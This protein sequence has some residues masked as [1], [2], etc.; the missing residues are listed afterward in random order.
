MVIWAR[1]LREVSKKQKKGK[2]GG[3]GGGNTDYSYYGSFA[4]YIAHN[5]FGAVPFYR[6][7]RV[8]LN[9][10]LFYDASGDTSAVTEGRMRIHLG[11]TNQDVDPMLAAQEPDGAN[12]YDDEPYLSPAYRSGQCVL[13]FDDLP[14]AEYNN[15]FPAVSAEVSTNP[16][17][18]TLAAL[19]TSI[20]DRSNV[21]PANYSVTGLSGN[22]RGKLIQGETSAES[23]LSDLMDVYAFEPVDLDGITQFLHISRSRDL[24]P[25]PIEYLGSSEAGNELK[26]RVKTKIKP[27]WEFPTSIEVSYIDQDEDYNKRTTIYQRSDRDERDGENLSKDFQIVLNPQQGALLAQQL[28]HREWR[29]RIE[30]VFVLPFYFL[31]VAVG[32]LIELPDEVGLPIQEVTKVN[33]GANFAIEL[34]TI[35]YN[36][37]YLG[38]IRNIISVPVPQE[39]FVQDDTHLQILD[40]PSPHDSYKD[41]SLFFAVGADSTWRGGELYVSLDG[42]RYQ[43]LQPLT[44]RDNTGTTV[45]AL[46]T[47]SHYFFDSH[48]VLRVELAHDDQQLES[49]DAAAMDLGYNIALVG[50]EIIQFQNATL[51]VD[52]IWELTGLRRG[53]RGTEQE[54]DN[55]AVGDRFVVLT[56]DFGSFG[57]IEGNPIYIGETLHF[58]APNISQ[59][60][61]GVPAIN[62][63]VAGTVYMPP[64]PDHLKLTANADGS[65][66]V[67]WKIRARCRY[68]W[69]NGQD[70]QIPDS[71]K[72]AWLDIYDGN[73]LLRTIFSPDP[74]YQYST[75]SQVA[76][77]GAT[78]QSLRVGVYSSNTAVSAVF[79]GRGYIE[80]LLVSAIND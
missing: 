23:C 55:H 75:A 79:K 64:A 57:E 34:T 44:S 21:P 3:S 36:S 15:T 13:A 73:N 4:V 52:G 41:D 76:D 32:D 14:L 8:W 58:K 62:H 61:T 26:N 9:S 70:V 80:N 37:Q 45:N 25:I 18:P 74:E 63:D 29:K 12:S 53:M 69:A 47:G 1:P 50:N 17:D 51:G 46:G 33:I 10:E 35:T 78:V 2:G 24:F 31:D 59:S 38:G 28:L 72:G 40:I 5:G 77:F 71:E 39:V 67:S 48:S 19:V 30:S 49:V 68:E 27:H 42:S 60:V 20:C 66:V 54:I 22:I 43:S 16:G 56:G 11:T 7:H 65:L 6:V